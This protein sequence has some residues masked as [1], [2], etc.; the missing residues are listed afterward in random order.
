MFQDLNCCDGLDICEGQC[1]K[2]VEN[3]VMES[4]DEIVGYFFQCEHAHQV[5]ETF[6]LPNKNL[7]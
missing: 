6:M 4:N 3:V 2:F 5:V 1:V 7:L